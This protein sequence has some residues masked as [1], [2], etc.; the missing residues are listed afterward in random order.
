MCIVINY[1]GTGCAFLMDEGHD[2]LALCM[3][4]GRIGHSDYGDTTP[5]IA[6]SLSLSP[7][8]LTKEY[9]KPFVFFR[10]SLGAPN[11]T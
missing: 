7:L 1:E 4:T 8:A 11:S 5:A 6:Y 2:K 3:R 9:R 10:S